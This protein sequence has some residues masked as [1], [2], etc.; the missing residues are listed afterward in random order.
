MTDKLTVNTR[1]VMG[2]TTVGKTIWASEPAFIQQANSAMRALQ[3]E[4]MSALKQ[5]EDVT[6]EILLSVMQPIFEESQ[7]LV[8]VSTGDLKNSGYVELTSFRGTPTVEIG[9]AKG[10]NPWYAMYIHEMI[11]IPHKP[12]TQAKF[13]EKPVNDHLSTLQDDIANAYKKF[14]GL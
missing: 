13:L 3:K 14:S 8:P 12:P 7:V 5:F 11:N 9:Y 2:K 10:G 1:L 6:P 4:I